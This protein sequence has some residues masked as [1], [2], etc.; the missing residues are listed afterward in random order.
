MTA[1]QPRP[2]VAAPV[3]AK[4]QLKAPPAKATAAKAAPAGKVPPEV[5]DA[6]ATSAPPPAPS[7][8]S[9]P[10]EKS[11]TEAAK[12]TPES[13][14]VAIG[15]AV[16]TAPAAPKANGFAP[17]ANGA[18]GQ[19]GAADSLSLS[20]SRALTA[21]HPGWRVTAEGHIEHLTPDGWVRMLADQTSAFRVV[22]VVGSDVWAGGT[23][24]ALFYSSD[25]GQH[26][27][28]ASLT[29]ANGAETAA[30]VS[31]RFDDSQHGVV[32]TDS[33]AQYATSDGGANWTKP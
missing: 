25:G 15:G 11:N 30:I 31:I 6:M 5:Y 12:A 2:E 13:V 28:K 18:L 16:R 14:G 33:G 29:T 7:A 8:A 10:P 27:K 24:G 23:G 32:V 22:S 3:I 19:Y 21:A 4:P 17:S 1:P 20:V 26:W 9:A